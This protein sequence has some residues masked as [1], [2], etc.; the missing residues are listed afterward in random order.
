MYFA[1]FKTMIFLPLNLK[2]INGAIWRTNPLLVTAVIGPGIL[3]SE[4]REMA[5]IQ[6]Y[7]MESTVLTNSL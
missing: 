5:L 7:F 4:D 6:T 3:P 2:P 1:P